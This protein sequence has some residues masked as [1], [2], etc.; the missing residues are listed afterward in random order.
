MNYPADIFL[1][2]M[3]II[4]KFCIIFFSYLSILKLTNKKVNKIN[5][6]IIAII[7]LISAIIVDVIHNVVNYIYGLMIMIIL[8]AS[9]A[10]ISTKLNYNF[11][12][13]TTLIVLSINY[14]SF[15]ISI[16]LEF[17]IK[18]LLHINNEYL[19]FIIIM[20]LY[21]F[22]IK[23]TLNFKKFKY[24]LDFL[25]EKFEN[26][27]LNIILLNISVVVLLSYIILTSY[28]YQASKMIMIPFIFFAIILFL[29]IQKILQM[30][31]K[32]NLLVQDLEE[33]KK[34][35]EDKKKEIEEL[36]KEILESNK[37][38]HTIA[39]KQRSLEHKIEK[40]MLNSEIAEEIDLKDRL[41]KIIEKDMTEKTELQKSGIEIIDDM[42]EYMQSE[43]I[44]NKINFQLTLS[45]N[46]HSMIN[47]YIKKE[48][49]ETLLADHIKDAIIALQH[50][51][52]KN[53]S[54]LVRLGKIEGVYGLYIYDSGIEF[55]KDTLLKL[56]KEP[57]T[58]H[59]ENGG[60]GMGFM[61][62]FDTLNKYKASLV[63]KEIGKPT[64]NNFT[65]VIMIKFDNNN[66]FKVESYRKELENI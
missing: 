48:D 18:K 63:I 35:L 5:I 43:C 16:I 29:S 42:L 8:I 36:E 24:G 45:G 1:I 11:S 3:N 2:I 54:I 44:K 46:I 61:N 41:N 26:E 32:H 4:K 9:I 51:N 14:I 66:K 17:N 39:H 33:T 21:S 55:E 58:T 56:G 40:L 12:I 53:K 64:I 6:I 19:N 57:V 59:K 62:T 13:V 31:Y 28:N 49:L 7:F 27:Y 37:R 50:S 23:K 30:Y 22:I 25:K 65:K 34:E 47:N 15:I 10:S 20:I 38:S 60:T 52:N